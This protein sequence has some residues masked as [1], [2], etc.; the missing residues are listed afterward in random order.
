QRLLAR[1]GE[2]LSS[3][4]HYEHTLQ[5]VADLAVPDIADWCGVSMPDRNGVI[6]QV[7]VAHSDPDKVAFARDYAERYPAR[8]TEDGG[9][10]QVLR[11]GRSQLV[12]E[13]P[14][15]LLDQAVEDP[16]QRELLRSVGMRSVII[17]PMTGAS[18]VPFGV[19]SLIN[20]ESGRVFSQADLELCEELGRR[21][22][23]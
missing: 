10:A 1:A 20:A 22:G 21:A 7:A 11:D 16:E 14:D 13:I 5:E 6:A 12:V 19:I 9:A 8:V 18:G 4:L 17:V 15:E 23:I 3:S 2:A